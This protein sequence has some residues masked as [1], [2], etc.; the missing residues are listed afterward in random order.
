MENSFFQKYAKYSKAKPK[1]YSQLN[2]Y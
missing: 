1:I 2:Q